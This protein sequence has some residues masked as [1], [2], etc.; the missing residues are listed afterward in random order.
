MSFVDDLSW[1]ND[2]DEITASGNPGWTLETDGVGKVYVE[3]SSVTDPAYKARAAGGGSGYTAYVCTDQGSDDHE[4]I[5]RIKQF[6]ANGRYRFVARYVDQDNWWGFYLGGTGSAGLR[7]SKNISGSTSDVITTQ[8]EDEQWVKVKADGSDITFELGGT[9]ATPSWSQQGSTQSDSNT[10]TR[11]GIVCDG[12]D[13]DA[14]WGYFEAAALGGGGT[15]VTVPQANLTFSTTAPTVDVPAVGIDITPDHADLALSTEAPDVA[16]TDNRDLTV[17]HAD[18]AL[19]TEAPDVTQTANVALEVGAAD[20]ALT[21]EAPTAEATD[22][23][24]ITVGHA[25]LALSSEAPDVL[26]TEAGTITVGQADLVLSSKAPSVEQTTNAAF[27]PAH[28]DLTFSTTAPEVFAGANIGI[29]PDAASLL[30]SSVAPSLVV[31]DNQAISIGG[32][33]LALSTAAPTVDQTT[34]ASMSPASADLTLGGFAPSVDYSGS[35]VWTPITEATTTWTAI[36]EA[37]TT[38]TEI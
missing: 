4:T 7:L 35:I 12:L 38:W 17:S 23:K 5:G 20:L 34:N 1:A 18:L 15:T 37:S 9:S 30:L 27:T 26:A 14:P 16:R 31:A 22:N 24:A 36:T 11:Q 6:E 13:T 2:E 29:S 33:N 32:A 28:A 19:S 10:N 8:G 21:T 25:D 3:T